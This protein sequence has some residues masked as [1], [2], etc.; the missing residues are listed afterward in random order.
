M[1]GGATSRAEAVEGIHVKAAGV[2]QLPELSVRDR[3]MIAPHAGPEL[4]IACENNFLGRGRF[5]ETA[6][7][8]PNIRDI[9][10]AKLNDITEALPITYTH[11]QQLKGG[12]PGVGVAQ[13]IDATRRR[14]ELR[15]EQRS[16]RT[17]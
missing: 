10:R 6:Q 2:V 4:I 5:E 11:P 15:L 13:M 8:P 1:F 3:A 14:I 7:H 16:W 12:V 9:F 17:V